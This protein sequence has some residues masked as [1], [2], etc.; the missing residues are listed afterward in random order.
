M[1]IVLIECKLYHILSHLNAN[2]MLQ[3]SDQGLESN[4][5]T[6]IPNLQAPSNGTISWCTRNLALNHTTIIH[7]L[8]CL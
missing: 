8:G 7:K 6:K 3:Q 5:K 4:I 2:S 1:G